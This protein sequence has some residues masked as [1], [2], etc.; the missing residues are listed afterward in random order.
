MPTIGGDAAGRPP[1]RVGAGEARRAPAR[2]KPAPRA[3]G[4]EAPETA[5]AE[6]ETALELEGGPES[7]AATPG[8]RAVTE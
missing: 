4:G 6:P 1:R 5:P 2:R 7:K 3:A 8:G